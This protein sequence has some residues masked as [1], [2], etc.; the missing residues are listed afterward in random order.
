M[1]D[2]AAS[3]FT[4]GRQNSRE[5]LRPH[6]RSKRRQSR[7]QQAID[8]LVVAAARPHPHALRRSRGQCLAKG[9]RPAPLPA[10]VQRSDGLVQPAAGPKKVQSDVGAGVG[11]R[12]AHRFPNGGGLYRLDHRVRCRTLLGTSPCWAGRVRVY[13]L[14]PIRWLWHCGRPGLIACAVTGCL[15]PAYA[16]SFSHGLVWR[17]RWPR[18]SPPLLLVLG[19][20]RCPGRDRRPLTAGGAAVRPQ[21]RS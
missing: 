11:T 1:V 4:I 17:S 13:N 10:D 5:R 20:P 19:A 14:G 7:I 12:F 8:H 9:P 6:V 3:C 16:T 2:A 21:W 18:Q 15:S